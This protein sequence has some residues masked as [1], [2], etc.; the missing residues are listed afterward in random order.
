MTIVVCF[1]QPTFCYTCPQAIT[2]LQNVHVTTLLCKNPT[3]E[4][5]TIPLE[6]TSIRQDT[7]KRPAALGHRVGKLTRNRSSSSKIKKRSSVLKRKSREKP[8]KIGDNQSSSGTPSPKPPSSPESFK[9]R[10]KLSMKTSM[11]KRS[12]QPQ[13]VSPLARSTSPVALSQFVTPCSSPPG[14]MQSL[15]IINTPP[16]SPPTNSRRPERHISD[17]SL[18]KHHKKSKSECELQLPLQQRTSPH[19]SPL[20]QRAMSPEGGRVYPHRAETLPRVPRK[21]VSYRLSADNKA[22]SLSSH[23]QS[24]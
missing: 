24:I 1:C 15:A 22:V 7:K 14:S 16:A 18:L 3:I 19:T 12:T 11:R 2:G 6:E 20:L 17:S 9:N 23:E 13:P 10:H 8:P 21:S 5:S 4:V